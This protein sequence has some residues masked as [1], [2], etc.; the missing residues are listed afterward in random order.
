M[1][2]GGAHVPG[3]TEFDI[4]SEP[5]DKSLPYHTDNVCKVQS[6]NIRGFHGDIPC[7]AMYSEAGTALYLQR[8]PASPSGQHG[9]PTAG[10]ADFEGSDSD[11]ITFH[12]SPGP[13]REINL[14]PPKGYSG[15]DVELRETTIAAAKSQNAG[16]TGVN[17]PVHYLCE[18][19]A[20]IYPDIE[21]KLLPCRLGFP[22]FHRERR[23]YF[24]A[25]RIFR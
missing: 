4:F 17:V 19:C 11:G 21:K 3:K 2:N 22:C 23:R 16:A 9:F 7:P 24:P 6:S 15:W 14:S 13:P 10:H 12:L 8:K 1:V 5:A 25:P 18:R 20:E